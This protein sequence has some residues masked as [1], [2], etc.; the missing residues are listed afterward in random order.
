MVTQFGCLAP[1]LT[2]AKTV[3]AHQV[4]RPRALDSILFLGWKKRL[5]KDCLKNRDLVSQI[6]SQEGEH[7]LTLFSLRG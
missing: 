5:G 7:G 1:D 6:K 3:L 4:P 2:A